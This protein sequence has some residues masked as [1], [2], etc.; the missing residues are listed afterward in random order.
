ML[1]PT[2]MDQLELYCRSPGDQLSRSPPS[3][4]VALLLV[5]LLF[6]LC[7]ILSAKILRPI[8]SSF[9]LVS[10]VIFHWHF[11]F[12]LQVLLRGGIIMSWKNER[13]EEVLF[14]AN[15]VIFLWFF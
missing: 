8:L 1:F 10:H 2:P 5:S 13:R 3:C 14:V 11:F 15:K 9:F 12:L 4:L 7:P 6:H